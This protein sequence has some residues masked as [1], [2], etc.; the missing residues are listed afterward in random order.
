MRHG[1]IAVV[2]PFRYSAI[3]WAMIVGFVVWGDVPDTLML[4]GTAMIIATG[5]YTFHRERRL[6]A[7]TAIAKPGK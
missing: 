6:S 2:A 4:T 5:V 7:R 1:D 3:I